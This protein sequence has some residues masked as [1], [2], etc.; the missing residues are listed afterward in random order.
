MIFVTIFR[1]LSLYWCDKIAVI[2]VHATQL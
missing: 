2:S 1:K